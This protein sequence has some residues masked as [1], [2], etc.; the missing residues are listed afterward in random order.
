MKLVIQ[1]L[2][3]PRNTCSLTG[4]RGKR[5]VTTLA[6]ALPGSPARNC[7]LRRQIVPCRARRW[8]INFLIVFIKI[9][10]VSLFS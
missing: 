5:F 1:F 6:M 8:R 9:K 10:M 7:D 4:E 3:S 2:L